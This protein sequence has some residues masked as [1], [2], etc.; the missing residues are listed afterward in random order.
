MDRSLLLENKK[1]VKALALK[2]AALKSGEKG[3][4]S[5]LK[6]RVDGP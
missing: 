4:F 6:G 1:Y 2:D 5:F 3:G